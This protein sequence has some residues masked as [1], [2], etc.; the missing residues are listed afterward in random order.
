MG[1]RDFRRFRTVSSRS[2]TQ[3][4]TGPPIPTT[5]LGSCSGLQREIPHRTT[6]ERRSPC[7]YAGLTASGGL[8]NL[9]SAPE[10][11]LGLPPTA[12]G[13]QS[14]PHG[15]SDVLFRVTLTR[16]S[17]SERILCRQKESEESV[18]GPLDHCSTPRD[19]YS[20]ESEARASPLLGR[21]HLSL[22]TRVFRQLET[23]GYRSRDC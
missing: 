13:R 20:A 16:V 14:Q 17:R 1:S 23:V 11:P 9:K 8:R 3:I 5:P 22:S 18:Y 12:T 7:V 19:H 15:R 6:V 2:W 4:T 21:W 10:Y